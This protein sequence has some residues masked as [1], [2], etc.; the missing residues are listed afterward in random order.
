MNPERAARVA[1]ARLTEPADPAVT[2]LL[3]ARGY[4][5]ALAALRRGDPPKLAAKVAPRLA[6]LPDIDDV[7][8]A[9][10][11]QASILIPGDPGWPAALDDLPEPP[12][13]LWALGST[14]VGALTR[15]SVALVGARAA[16]AYGVDQAAGLAAALTDRRVVVVS[17][18]AFGIDAAAHRG[19]L[20]AGGPT[21]AVLACGIDRPYPQAHATL[22]R[23]I[24]ADGAVLTELPPGAAP[25]RQRFL[26]RNR[27][28]AALSLGTVVVEAA[29][30]SGSLQT[31]AWAERLARPVGAVPGPVTSLTSAG[32]HEAIRDLRA[33]LV[34]D[35]DDIVDLIGRYGTDAAEI[36]RAPQRP[37]DRLT[38]T[39]Y[40]VWQVL[41]TAGQGALV[42]ALAERAGLDVLSVQA[43]LGPLELAGLAHQGA[44]GY[45]RSRAG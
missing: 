29:I 8:I 25:Y 7:A 45:V 32:C 36:R 34:T 5:D 40:A 27:L 15:R 1:F 12:H 35:A 20:A 17:G 38:E 4:P 24:A 23:E 43:A 3:A 18:A 44:A 28:I 11:L 19:A 16:T 2:E 21:V 42:E 30:R 33:V 31:A 37:E 26:Q 13:C 22:L 9:E 14:E 10:R 6:K 39:Q 41:P